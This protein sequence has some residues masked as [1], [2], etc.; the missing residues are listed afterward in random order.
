VDIGK[1]PNLARLIA[2]RPPLYTQVRALQQCSE[3]AGVLN[4]II[5]HLFRVVVKEKTFLE[6]VSVVV[7]LSKKGYFSFRGLFV[8]RFSSTL[9]F[10][11]LNERIKLL[12]KE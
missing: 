8:S 7:C 5:N 4:D 6:E 1:R 11:S 3:E 10:I 12:Y 2:Q 9:I